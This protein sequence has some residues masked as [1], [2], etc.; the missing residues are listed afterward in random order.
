MSYTTGVSQPVKIPFHVTDVDG[1]S[2]SLGLDDAAFEKVLLADSELSPVTV[3][4]TEVGQGY[5]CAQFTPDATGLWHIGITTPAQD[6]LSASVTVGLYNS[7]DALASLRKATFNRLEMDFTAQELVLYEDDG[8]AVHQRW[9][10]ATARG[11]ND[12]V[13]S[14]PGVQTRRKPPLLPI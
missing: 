6:V 11:G 4:I 7:E 3:V 5:Y 2:S 13:T 14:Q 9:P 12:I 1:I 10:L 8:V